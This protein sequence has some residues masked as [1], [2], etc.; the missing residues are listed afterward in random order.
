MR[1]WTGSALFQVM[2]CRLFGAKSVLEPVL[3]YCQ[4]DTPEQMSVKSES[5]YESLFENNAILLW[6][7]MS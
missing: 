1:Q 5:K 6:G 7:E 2:A 3:H 4:L